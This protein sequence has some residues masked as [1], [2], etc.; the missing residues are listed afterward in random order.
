MS[1]F[2]GRHAGK[3]PED[4]VKGPYGGK[5]HAER[6]LADGNAGEQ[7]LLCLGD[8]QAVYKLVK[9]HIHALVEHMGNIIPVEVQLF[10]KYIQGQWL[11]EIFQA[12][13]YDLLY[14]VTVC[15]YWG[16]GKQR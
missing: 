15:G 9:A 16:I 1:I 5:S 14:A 7:L 10:G 4:T 6:Y 3:F 2:P 11:V 13:A 12:V 8:T